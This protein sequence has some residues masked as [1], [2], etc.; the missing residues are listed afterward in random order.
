MVFF[1]NEYTNFFIPINKDQG[2]IFSL[3]TPFVFL[4]GIIILNGEG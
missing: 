3:Q 1:H 2:F 4:K